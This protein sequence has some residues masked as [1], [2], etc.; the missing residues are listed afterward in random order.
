MIKAS[1]DWI[2][3]KNRADPL[4]E[5]EKVLRIFLALKWRGGSRKELEIQIW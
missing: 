3:K 1:K 2:K 4:E 5:M